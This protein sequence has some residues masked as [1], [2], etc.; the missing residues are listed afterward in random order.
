MYDKRS[1]CP[2]EDKLFTDSRK[3]SLLLATVFEEAEGFGEQE[4]IFFNN[5]L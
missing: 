4:I 3:N 5:F 1:C 2:S